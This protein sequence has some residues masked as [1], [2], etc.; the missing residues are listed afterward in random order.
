MAPIP[1]VEYLITTLCSAFEEAASELQSLDWGA[2]VDTLCT[3]ARAPE[4]HVHEFVDLYQNLCPEND[5]DLRS[6]AAGFIRREKFGFQRFWL[7][8]DISS[9]LASLERQE[10]RD[11]LESLIEDCP[12]GN[13]SR[14]HKERMNVVE[15]LHW[16]LE[17][18]EIYGVMWLLE[19]ALW[20]ARMESG[21][22][23]DGESRTQC[24][25]TCGIPVVVPKVAA[26]L[27]NPKPF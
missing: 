12:V 16:R 19:L 13:T 9:R 2:F 27:L 14:A 10:W 6:T 26:F 3:K 20:K 8:L 25:V 21:G 24:R 17:A 23:Q 11:E 5:A 4:E 22:G 7:K 1:C 15:S 18:Y